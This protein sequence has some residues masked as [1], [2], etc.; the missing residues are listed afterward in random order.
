MEFEE[1]VRRSFTIKAIQITEE[2]I[3]DVAVYANTVVRIDSKRWDGEPHILILTEHPNR[4]PQMHP[5]FIGDWAT[6]TDAGLQRYKD[7]RFRTTFE[8]K[9]VDEDKRKKVR[10]LVEK[11]LMSQPSFEARN[12]FVSEIMQ[13]F[14]EG[15]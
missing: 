5:L 9:P 11:A 14:Q 13:I 10:D 15:S 3:G 6:E 12:Q 2:N 4:Q 8:K 1:Y 7:N